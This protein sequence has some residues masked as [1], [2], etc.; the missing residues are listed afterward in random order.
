MMQH[1]NEQK[2]LIEQLDEQT[3]ALQQENDQLHQR[4]DWAEKQ[5]RFLSNELN[6]K[7]VFASNQHKQI[8]ELNTQLA[9]L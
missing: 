2:D 1:C 6:Q 3:H 8:N 9:E 5:C 4:C 7:E